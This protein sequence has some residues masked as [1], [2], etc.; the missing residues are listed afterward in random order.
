MVQAREWESIAV[1]GERPD[2]TGESEDSVNEVYLASIPQITPISWTPQALEE[3]L[4]QYQLYD[5]QRAGVAHLVQRSSALL[6]DDMG[7]GKTRQSIV[8]A[9]IQAKGRPILI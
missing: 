9:H 4:N 8:A 3:A 6:A 1:G 7:L 5:Y 2:P